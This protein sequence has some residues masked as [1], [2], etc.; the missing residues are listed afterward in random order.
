MMQAV[1]DAGVPRHHDGQPRAAV[2]DL[3]MAESDPASGPDESL[4]VV[5]VA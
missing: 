1:S 2:Y 3:V 4:P 5:V